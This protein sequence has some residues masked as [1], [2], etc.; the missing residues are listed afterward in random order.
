MFTEDKKHEE[1]DP[2]NEEDEDEEETFSDESKELDEED[3]DDESGNDNDDGGIDLND[4][5][6]EDND[7]QTN[8]NEELT[9]DEEN[10]EEEEKLKENLEESEAS[11][12]RERDRREEVRPHKEFVLEA[13]LKRL[14]NQQSLTIHNEEQYINDPLSHIDDE[15]DEEGQSNP[16]IFKRISIGNVMNNLIH[17]PPRNDSLAIVAYKTLSD[18]QCKTSIVHVDLEERE[19]KGGYILIDS[20]D[21]DALLKSIDDIQKDN[22]EAAMYTEL[23]RYGFLEEAMRS[24]SES[25][26]MEVL[27]DFQR[28]TAWNDDPT[29]D[30]YVIIKQEEERA[31][32]FF[33]PNIHMMTK[34]HMVKWLTGRGLLNKFEIYEKQTLPVDVDK[35]KAIAWKYNKVWD[36]VLVKRGFCTC[37]ISLDVADRNEFINQKMVNHSRSE[38]GLNFKLKL[39]EYMAKGN[40]SITTGSLL[41]L[42][43]VEITTHRSVSPSKSK[44]HPWPSSPV[45]ATTFF[46]RITHLNHL[47]FAYHHYKMQ[48]TQN[49][50]QRIN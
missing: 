42:L 22:V 4:E 38:R 49:T 16:E 33:H 48:I 44:R 5:Y 21:D 18:E 43:D 32:K 27:K 36:S 30:I 47:A 35:M 29:F 15:D 37:P 14:N 28:N 46:R 1:D 10:V 6:Q 12:K 13:R 23:Y 45:H 24:M 26:L 19:I 20:N 7:P 31:R 8:D 11:L 9:G 41:F 3:S 25:E 34:G 17:S 50:S 39:K 40:Q 2:I